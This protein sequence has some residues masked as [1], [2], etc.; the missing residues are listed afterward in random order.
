MEC[1]LFA[2]YGRQYYTQ[3]KMWQDWEAGKDFS[4]QGSWG[5]YCSV[6]DVELLQQTYSKVWLVTQLGDKFRVV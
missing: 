5:P 3:T 2:A 6:R 4:M 1:E